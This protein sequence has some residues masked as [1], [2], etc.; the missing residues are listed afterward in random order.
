MSLWFNPAFVGFSVVSQTFVNWHKAPI[1][2]LLN[3][4]IIASKVTFPNWPMAETWMKPVD[5]SILVTKSEA[6]K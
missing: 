5:L 3:N 2:T 1:M 4:C 6:P